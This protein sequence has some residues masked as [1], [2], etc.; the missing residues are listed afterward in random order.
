VIILVFF[1]FC[2]IGVRTQGFLL[3][4][5]AFYYMSYI[6]ALFALIILE[7]GLCFLLGV[8]M[9]TL[10]CLSAIAEMARM[11]HH[12]QHFSVEKGVSVTVQAGL[13]L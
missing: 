11:Y 9:I 1:F 12:A 2:G 10:L 4:G 6:S 5:Q 8:G 3:A 13:G 7:I